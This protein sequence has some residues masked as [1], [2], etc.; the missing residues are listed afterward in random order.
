MQPCHA[1]T[2]QLTLCHRGDYRIEFS[3]I[4]LFGNR[5]AAHRN[6]ELTQ[7][8]FIFVLELIEHLI[9]HDEW[10]VSVALRII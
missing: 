4:T 10:A 9:G 2:V 8:D 1:D 5:F 3:V 7:F 6:E